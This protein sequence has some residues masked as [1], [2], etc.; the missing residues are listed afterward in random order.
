MS[1]FN[2]VILVLIADGFSHYFNTFLYM[3]KHFDLYEI[4]LSVSDIFIQVV[5]VKVL[6]A[7]QL[8]DTLPTRWGNVTSNRKTLP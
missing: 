6:L 5:G 2:F 4:F 3:L 8:F 1:T 7:S